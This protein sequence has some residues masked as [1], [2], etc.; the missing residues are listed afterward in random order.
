MQNQ[1]T[2]MLIWMLF[3]FTLRAP[4]VEDLFH[5]CAGLTSTV[6]FHKNEALAS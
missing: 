4:D 6:E 1:V 5:A 2:E 3:Q